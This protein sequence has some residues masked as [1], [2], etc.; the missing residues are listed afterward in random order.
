VV[1]DVDEGSVTPNPTSGLDENGY[2][3]EMIDLVDIDDERNNSAVMIELVAMRIAERELAE[4]GPHMTE[5][6]LAGWNCEEVE[7]FAMSA[8]AYQ[9]GYLARVIHDHYY[10]DAVA[11]L[12]R[13][14]PAE[15]DDS[16]ERIVE[17]AFEI[18]SPEAG[19]G[20]AVTYSDG[21]MPFAAP[22]YGPTDPWAPFLDGFL[23]LADCLCSGM[24]SVEQW[25][26]VWG[27]GRSQEVNAAPS[28]GE[29]RG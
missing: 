5:A 7:P 10:S 26:Q 8:A 25:H 4:E 3:G 15:S 22:D 18:C 27:D 13:M 23:R 24:T 28:G 19:D 29:A 16:E 17:W 6:Q 2:G 20:A 14:A 11:G 12:F 21:S 9:E 1:A